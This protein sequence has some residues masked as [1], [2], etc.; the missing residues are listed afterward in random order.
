MICAFHPMTSPNLPDV[1][2]KAPSPDLFYNERRPG[3]EIDLNVMPHVA[4]GSELRF[5]K[6]VLSFL[7]AS[8]AAKAFCIAVENKV[9]F[10]QAAARWD[11]PVMIGSD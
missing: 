5:C 2:S 11:S 6:V 3:R 8:R 9:I 10:T 4:V 7:N 1:T